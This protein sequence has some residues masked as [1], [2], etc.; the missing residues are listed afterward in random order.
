MWLVFEHGRCEEGAE[1]KL[2]TDRH[3]GAGLPLHW[4]GGGQ[5]TVSRE[6]TVTGWVWAGGKQ[7][8]KMLHLWF[9]EPSWVSTLLLL[10]Y[11]ALL[12]PLRVLSRAASHLR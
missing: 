10:T 6:N 1:K 2:G 12:L 7:A 5:Q 3:D 8:E 9:Q 11:G 4:E